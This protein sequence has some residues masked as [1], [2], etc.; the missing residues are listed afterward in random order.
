MAVEYQSFG[1]YVRSCTDREAKIAA[2]DE[3]INKLLDA[4]ATG[5]DTSH[6]NEYWLNDGQVQIKNIY[7]N[8]TE[9]MD[10]IKRWES[11]RNYYVQQGTGRVT[12]LVDSRNFPGC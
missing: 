4:A 10:G 2:I 6:L 1:D 12:R 8:M 3:I 11:L 9:L 7:R 5:A